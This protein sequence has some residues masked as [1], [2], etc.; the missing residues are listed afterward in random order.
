MLK[1]SL[2]QVKKS[3]LNFKPF[4][5]FVVRNL[6]PRKNL[7]KLNS[8]LP[9]FEDITEKKIYFQSTSGTKK[10][11]LPKSYRYKKLEK[12]KNFKDLNNLFR[13][14]KPYIIKKFDSSIK[15]Y[16][17]KKFHQSKFSQHSTFSVMK[18]GYIKSAHLDRRDHLIHVLYYSNSQSNKG[19][20][21]KILKLKKHKKVYDIFP[22]K[23][24]LVSHKKYKVNNNFCL[25][26]LN[27]P[28]SYHSVTKYNGEKDR[29]YFY[30]VYD[31]PSNQG[32]AKLK[33]RK[34]G[35]NQNNFWN[36]KVQVASSKRKSKF[37][38]E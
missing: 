23:K 27:V 20:D 4:P 38:S 5:Y 11:L 24:D 14:L 15:E 31:F 21:I 28:W 16:V 22:S 10:T 9:S 7:K 3:K 18:K 36:S 32:G 19:G 1:Y 13:D 26:T 29:K 33:N 25:F 2:N 35:N 8:I 30:I 12:N 37:F 6:I 17:K 34:K